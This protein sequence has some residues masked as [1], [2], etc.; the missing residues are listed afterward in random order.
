[1]YIYASAC[2]LACVHEGLIC[3]EQW[4]QLTSAVNVVLEPVQEKH[5]C[6]ISVRNNLHRLNQLPH[7]SFISRFLF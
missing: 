1:M 6:S 7:Q 4:A 3:T 2:M 5:L